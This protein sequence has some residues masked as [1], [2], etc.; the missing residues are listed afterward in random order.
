MVKQSPMLRRSSCGSKKESKRGSK[1][2]SKRGSKKGSKR[3]S[4]RGHHSK[5]RRGDRT[6]FVC[7][8]FWLFFRSGLRIIAI[9]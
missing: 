5:L 2:G 9:S 8:P 4:K 7:R 6:L 1:K 3:G